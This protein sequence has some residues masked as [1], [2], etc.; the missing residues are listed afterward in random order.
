MYETSV[1]NTA[2]FNLFLTRK[3]NVWYS[4]C[5]GEW[6][7]PNTWVSNAL[8]R[9]NVTVPQPNDTVYINHTI[10]MDSNIMVNNMYISGKLQGTSISA[11]SITINGDL[12][13][14]G[15]GY[16]DLS[17][18]FNNLILNGYDNII[19]YA[20]FNAGNYSTVAYNGTFDQFIMNLPYHSLSANNSQKYQTSDLSLSGNFSQFSNYEIGPYS[21]TVNGSSTCGNLFSGKLTKNSGTGSI[22]FVGAVDFEGPID[23]SGGIRI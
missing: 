23:F 8:D 7:N 1:V 12:Q 18:Q 22:L 16:L 2:P 13:V 19:P 4:V 11:Y 17:L 14:S 9:K 21:L 10:T 20:N 6:S 5:D 3:Q 15:S